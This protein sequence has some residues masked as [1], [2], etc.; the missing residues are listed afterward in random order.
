MGVFRFLPPS[1]F[2]RCLKADDH[3][4]AETCSPHDPLRNFGPYFRLSFF[5]W[6]LGGA[7]RISL[8]LHISDISAPIG[9]I[10]LHTVGLDGGYKT[11]HD[12][13]D[14]YFRF[15]GQPPQ[16]KFFRPLL[17]AN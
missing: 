1:S 5:V 13:V 9:A 16:T 6:P 8:T 12:I 15:G 4:A 3:C 10:F 7:K 17:N 11:A 14:Y 2:L